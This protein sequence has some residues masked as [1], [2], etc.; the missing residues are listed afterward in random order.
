MGLLQPA[1]LGSFAPG[2]LGS[3][4]PGLQ[5]PVRGTGHPEYALPHYGGLAKPTT[6]ISTGR[7]TARRMECNVLG[8]SEAHGTHFAGRTTARRMECN[9][10][11][12]SGIPPRLELSIRQRA[13]AGHDGPPGR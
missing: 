5:V 2:L 4:A 6:P 1:L 10:P 8:P 11:D 7:T 13:P 9:V 12:P 3:G